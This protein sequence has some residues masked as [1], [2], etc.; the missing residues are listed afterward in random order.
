MIVLSNCLTDKADEGSRK[1]ATSLVKRLGQ[2]DSK[3]T[4]ITYDCHCSLETDHLSVNKFLLNKKLLSMLRRKNEPVL[5]LPSPAKTLPMAIRLWILSRA[6]KKGL[7]VLITM[8]FPVSGVGKWLLK[9][10]K[11]RI[12][13]LS[14]NAS[15]QYSQ[16]LG[17]TVG[18]L[19]V[20]VDTGRF[21]PVSREQKIALREKYGIPQ[22]KPVVLHIGHLNRGRNVQQMLKLEDGFHGLLVVSTQTAHEQDGQ[23]RQQLLEK[24]SLTLIDRFVPNVEELYQ[25]SDVYLF[26]VLQTES[27][28]DS[29]LSALEAAA[30]GIPVV[31]TAFGELKE[32]LGAEGFYE[33]QS[34]APEDLNRLLHRAIEEKKNPRPAVI[35]YDWENAVSTVRSDAYDPSI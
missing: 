19:R 30:C 7:T 28:I 10:S 22:D 5:Y 21:C 17:K 29:P 35:P 14:Q 24:P 23:L 18:R 26:P 27:C 11:A 34:F 6:A 31:A 1:V 16:A 13:T 3:M 8:P 9:K 15:S 25:L 33:M 2:Q 20:G 32:L 4:V 12:L